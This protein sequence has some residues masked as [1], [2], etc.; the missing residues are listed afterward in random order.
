MGVRGKGGQVRAR[1]PAERARPPPHPLPSLPASTCLP[2]AATVGLA[3]CAIALGGSHAVAITV[4]SPGGR[5]TAGWERVAGTKAARGLG[6][7]GERLGGSGPAGMR[8][9]G[10]AGQALI[11]G[12]APRCHHRAGH[13]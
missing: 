12:G 6:F 4:G 10:R 7:E 13:E 2:L 1:R 3:S 8:M 11:R 5:T 9:A